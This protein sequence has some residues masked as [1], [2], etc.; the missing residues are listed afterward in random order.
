MHRAF[1]LKIVFHSARRLGQVRDWDVRYD[2]G[3]TL[4]IITTR[5]QIGS[6]A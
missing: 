6:L 2:G 1:C 4:D 3:M 5:T